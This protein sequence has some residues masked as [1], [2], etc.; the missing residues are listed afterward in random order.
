[1]I[2]ASNL[3]VPEF[4]RLHG[5]LSPER[6][7]QAVDLIEEIPEVDDAVG[8][9]ENARNQLPDD[10]EFLADILDLAQELQKSCK[11][12][13]KERADQLVALIEQA[14][15]DLSQSLGEVEEHLGNALN[16]LG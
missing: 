7:I 9:V 16:Y 14:R 1:M 4:Y 3:S 2:D 12:G 15:L 10:E 6:I 11:G 13:N 5:T 8:E